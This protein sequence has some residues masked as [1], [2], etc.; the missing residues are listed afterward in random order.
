[1]VRERK[2]A[3]KRSTTSKLR[4]HSTTGHGYI[5]QTYDTLDQAERAA[6]EIAAFKIPPELTHPKTK[7]KIPKG[8]LKIRRVSVL[9]GASGTAHAECE[10]PDHARG[11]TAAHEQIE[12]LAAAIPRATTG[13]RVAGHWC[14]ISDMT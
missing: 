12:A 7:K 8:R 14:C 3:P 5:W 11:S 9:E 6:K 2:G 1:M 10:A 4:P 13:L